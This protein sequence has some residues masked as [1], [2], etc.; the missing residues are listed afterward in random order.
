MKSLRNY[1]NYLSDNVH[2]RSK[3]YTEFYNDIAYVANEGR[4]IKIT[5]NVIILPGQK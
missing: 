1:V 4:H 2:A 5:T 3:I